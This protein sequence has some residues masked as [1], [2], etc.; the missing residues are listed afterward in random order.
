[1]NNWKEDNNTLIKTFEF[2]T[3]E[4]AMFF[5]QSAAPFISQ[6]DHHPTWT[7]TYNRITVKLCTHDAGNQV[8]EKDHALAT[9]LDKLFKI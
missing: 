4:E 9:Y 6:S 5:M 8:T 1:M 7:N 2:K 3:F